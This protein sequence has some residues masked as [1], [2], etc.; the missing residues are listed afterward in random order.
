MKVYIVMSEDD[1]FGQSILSVHDTSEK[2]NTNVNERLTKL[3][4]DMLDKEKVYFRE[5]NRAYNP[6]CPGGK[7]CSCSFGFE[8]EEYE[9]Q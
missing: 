7:W 9:V 6:T 1:G 4:K 8:V 5:G 2:A 3:I